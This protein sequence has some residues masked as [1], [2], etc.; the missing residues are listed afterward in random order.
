MFIIDSGRTGIAEGLRRDPDY[1]G[2][3]LS[4]GLRGKILQEIEETCYMHF[5]P[6]SERKVASD[7]SAAQTQFIVEFGE[8]NRFKQSQCLNTQ[9]SLRYWLNNMLDI[10]FIKSHINTLL[11]IQS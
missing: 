4:S 2:R 7:K 10:R 11:V 3:R 9:S 8:K 1:R 6:R 5:A